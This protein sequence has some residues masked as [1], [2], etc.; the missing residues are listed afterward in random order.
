[1]IN[2]NLHL[3]H[4]LRV[5]DISN[6]SVHRDLEESVAAED[7]V[8]VGHPQQLGRPRIKVE[9]TEIEN[10]GKDVTEKREKHH[11]F[12]AAIRPRAF[13]EVKLIYFE[14][15]V[16]SHIVANIIGEW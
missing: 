8:D 5:C 16:I 1:M 6:V 15:Q 12:P 7:D 11:R 4:L 13:R 14:N 3:V 10:S 2:L 9:E